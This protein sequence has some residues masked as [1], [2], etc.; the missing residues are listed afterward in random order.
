MGSPGVFIHFGTLGGR[1]AVFSL[2]APAWL[3]ARP[4][5]MTAPPSKALPSRRN[6]RR[7]AAVMILSMSVGSFIVHPPRE[8]G[9]PGITKRSSALFQEEGILMVGTKR[10]GACRELLRLIRSCPVHGVDRNFPSLPFPLR[11]G[12][13]RVVPMRPFLHLPRPISGAAWMLRVSLLAG[14][15][16]T[17]PFAGSGSPGRRCRAAPVSWHPGPPPAWAG[18]HSGRHCW[19]NRTRT[20]PAPG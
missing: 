1:L 20:G 15:H 4:P 6:R 17:V 16:S 3:P 18:R 14:V 9:L 7:E 5:A 10:G 19:G 11:H 8:I 12:K 13:G 2:A